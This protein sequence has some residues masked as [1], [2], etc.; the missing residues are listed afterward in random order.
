MFGVAGGGR[1]GRGGGEEGRGGGKEDRGH[2]RE[3][4]DEVTNVFVIIEGLD[5]GFSRLII[6]DMREV[7]CDSC[8]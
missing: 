8:W 3:A 7:E 1:E 6:S 4:V 5:H 2:T